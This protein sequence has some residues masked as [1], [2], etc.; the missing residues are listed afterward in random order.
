VTATNGS[1]ALVSPGERAP[2]QAQAETLFAESRGLI[3]QTL[4]SR[5]RLPDSVAIQMEE[6]LRVWFVR[7]CDRPGAPRP[8]DARHTLL[9]M[10][11]VFARASQKYR[12]E[13]GE[14]TWTEPLERLLRRDPADVAR[15]ASRPLKILYRRL[16]EPA[17]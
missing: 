16:H 14:R 3:H 8:A 2:A 4:V 9:V 1:S 6:D 11:C 17:R 7:F 5:Y 10:A 15:D 12:L 13:T